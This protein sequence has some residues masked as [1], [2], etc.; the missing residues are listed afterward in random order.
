MQTKGRPFS[1]DA[2]LVLIHE[3][4]HMS[5]RLHRW[6]YFIALLALDSTYAHDFWIECSPSRPATN[7]LVN[8]FL[9][10]GEHGV[11]TPVPRDPSR[12]ER[13]E[14]INATH[15]NAIIGREGGDPAGFFRCASPGWHMA[16]YRSTRTFIELP[17]LKFEEYLWMEG[18]DQIIATRHAQGDAAKPGRE[19]YSRC[20][21]EII[22]CGQEPAPASLPSFGFRLEINPA[23]PLHELHTA[24]TLTFQ[25]LFE[26]SAC[27]NALVTA[28]RAGNVAEQNSA[29]TDK[30][31][32]VQL[33]LSSSGRWIIKCVYMIP[34]P[35]D[36]DADWESLWASLTIQREAAK[37][38]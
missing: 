27:T 2:P 10:V 33:T 31:G 14:L 37:T 15:T 24:Q 5:S 29:R 30:E 6:L 38:P 26:G 13:F 25:V 35:K 3:S 9:K 1:T 17:A 19:I 21:K 32:L 23:S 16:G 7:E 8:V 4:R 36:T 34:A 28:L 22:V 12:I 18:L 11:G 20:A